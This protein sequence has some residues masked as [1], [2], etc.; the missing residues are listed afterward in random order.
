MKEF[1]FE[2]Y[3][4]LFHLAETKQDLFV[5]ILSDNQTEDNQYDVMLRNAVGCHL[6]Q[7]I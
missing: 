4:M 5:E 2:E 7:W 1:A 3:G 6:S